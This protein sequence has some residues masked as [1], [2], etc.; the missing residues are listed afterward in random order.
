MAFF[1]TPERGFYPPS[2]ACPQG[3]LVM[4]RNH[5]AQSAAC[6]LIIGVMAA[7]GPVH[8]E[9][10]KTDAD[11]MQDMEKT[12]QQIQATKD[13]N[14]RMELMQKHMDQMHAGMKAMHDRMGGSNGMGGCKDHMPEM[15]QMME[16]MMQQMEA[17]KKE[18]KK[19]H[20]HS[21]MRGGAG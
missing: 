14:Q 11:P 18:M 6:G 12:M 19:F 13:P 20:D 7:I 3:D 21:R 10:T 9:Q 1:E 2:E 8:A 17:E 4:K 16:K 15:Q 5:F